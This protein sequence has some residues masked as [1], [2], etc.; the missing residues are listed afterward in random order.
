MQIKHFKI[1]LV[2]KTLQL[3]CIINFKK[4]INHQTINQSP[5]YLEFRNRMLT[6]NF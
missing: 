1:P 6:C 3:L 4:S 2:F 5:Q